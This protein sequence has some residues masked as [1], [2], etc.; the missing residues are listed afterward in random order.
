MF[1]HDLMTNEKFDVYL[2]DDGT[3]DTVLNVYSIL[4]ND[5]IELEKIIYPKEYNFKND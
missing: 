4:G 1:I 5:S 3:L 2:V